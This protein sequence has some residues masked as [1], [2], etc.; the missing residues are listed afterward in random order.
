MKINKKGS[1]HVGIVLS[2]TL[3][4]TSIIFL[5]NIVGAPVQDIDEKTDNIDFIKSNFISYNSE[6][7]V[8]ARI[9]ASAQCVTISNPDFDFDSPQIY[10]NSNGNEIGASIVG[11]T[12][13]IALSSEMTKVYYSNSSFEKEIEYTSGGCIST[14]PSS[15]SYDNIIL[16]KNI[17][18]LTEILNDNETQFRDIMK[19]SNDYEFAFIFEFSN[20]TRI[21]HDITED[22]NIKTNIYSREYIVNY[23]SLK[24]NNQ[25]GKLEIKIW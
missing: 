17:N 21:G 12:S 5:Y 11:G 2:F 3:F 23:L 13:E 19:I 4:V 24:G 20:G 15:I 14:Q 18:Q 16:E 25:L 9:P 10:A 7:I 8:I 22:R 1:S 6:D